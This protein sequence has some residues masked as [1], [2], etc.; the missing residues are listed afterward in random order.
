MATTS[1]SKSFTLKIWDTCGDAALTWSI[2]GEDDATGI[3]AGTHTKLVGLAAGKWQ[4]GYGDPSDWPAGRSGINTR[5]I[6]VMGDSKYIISTGGGQSFS[7]GHGATTW[8]GD[9]CVDITGTD[10]P[11]DPVQWAIEDATIAAFPLEEFDVTEAQAMAGYDFAVTVS[12][13]LSTYC[14]PACSGSTNFF[15]RRIGQP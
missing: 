11:T 6:D 9:S 3:L 13:V 4:V 12:G 5:L 10:C 8:F 2:T 1:C 14:G 7:L 15:C